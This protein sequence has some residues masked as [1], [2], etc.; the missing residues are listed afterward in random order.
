MNTLTKSI[1]VITFL[2]VLTLSL[3]MITGNLSGYMDHRWNMAMDGFRMTTWMITPLL[4]TLGT[5][6]IVLWLVYRHKK[7]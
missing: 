7:A 4:V 6:L 2:A 1:L 3:L 5:G